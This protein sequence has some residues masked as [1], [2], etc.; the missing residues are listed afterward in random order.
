MCAVFVVHKHQAS[1]LHYDFRLEIAGA[2]ASWA[3]PKGPSLVTSVKRLAVRVEDHALDYGGFEGVI[4]ADE[5][6]AGPVMIWDEGEVVWPKGKPPEAMLEAGAL[7]FELK[8]TKLKGAFKLIHAK[9]GGD[10]RNWLL[11]KRTDAHA[12]TEDDVL[13]RLPNSARSGRRMEDIA[14]E[15]A[16]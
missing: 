12:E 3:V 8:G 1:R 5:Y 16:R 2:L 15:S 6:G 4:P 10:E 14:R 11:I 7:E 9:L 13:T